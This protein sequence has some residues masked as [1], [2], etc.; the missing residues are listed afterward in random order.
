MVFCDDALG[1]SSRTAVKNTRLVAPYSALLVR[2]RRS[3][4]S[5][6][7]RRSFGQSHCFERQVYVRSRHR[8]FGIDHSRRDSLR[9]E[10]EEHEPPA[11]VGEDISDLHAARHTLRLGVNRKNG[12][13][14]DV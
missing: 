1:S 6:A 5:K 11:V 10:P 14:I 12:S 9:I 4:N 8:V 2:V 3:H 7:G 13:S